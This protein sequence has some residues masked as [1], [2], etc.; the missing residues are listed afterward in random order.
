MAADLLTTPSSPYSPRT[1]NSKGMLWAFAMAD[2][3][4]TPCEFNRRR[5]MGKWN[6]GFDEGWIVDR[7]NRFGIHTICPLGQPSDDTEMTL[8]LLST[9]VKSPGSFTY[10]RGEA[11]KAYIAWANSGCPFM[12]RN[13]RTLFHGYTRSSTYVKRTEKAFENEEVKAHTRPNG[14]LMRVSPLALIGDRKA[15]HRAIREDVW[16]SNPNQFCI[17][18][19]SLYCDILW[20]LLRG[21]PTWES[22]IETYEKKWLEESGL[23]DLLKVLTDARSPTFERDIT[24]TRGWIC[25][26]LACA[27][28]HLIHKSTI[29]E[30]CDHLI[31]IDGDTDTNA[32]ITCALLGA[33]DGLEAMHDDPWTHAQLQVVKECTPTVTRGKRGKEVATVRPL[34]YWPT[35]IDEY[36]K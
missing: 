25:H 4:G 22:H 1:N 28:F 9:M 14:C 21:I 26:A 19:V 15:M 31:S 27:L 34:M 30:A 33:R 29:H 7:L 10:N 2:A 11:L 8:A 6:G 36:I 17:E 13:T 24:K 5:M 12:G 3:L 20:D 32:A 16:L 23:E 35:S 18:A